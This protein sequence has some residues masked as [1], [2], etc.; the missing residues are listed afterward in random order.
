MYTYGSA[1]VI[2]RT[3]VGEVHFEPPTHAGWAKFSGRGLREGVGGA[4]TRRAARSRAGRE[5][6]ALEPRC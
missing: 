4:N 6:F 5:D 1:P 2:C 3:A